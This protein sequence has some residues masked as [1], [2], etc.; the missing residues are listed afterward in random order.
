MICSDEFD[1]KMYEYFNANNKVPQSITEAIRECN[2]KHNNFNGLK[3]IAVVIL[4][5]LTISTS[6]VFA[7][8]I[9][10]FI[11]TQFKYFGTGRGVETAIEHGYIAKSDAEVVGNVLLYENDKIIDDINMN[12]NVEE[13]LITDDNLDIEFSVE[14]DSKINNYVD[15]GKIKNDNI[16]Y[17][18]SHLIILSDL[19]IVD[20]E[21]RVVYSNYY[22]K[23]LFDEFCRNNNIE[24]VYLPYTPFHSNFEYKEI[25]NTNEKVIVDMVYHFSSMEGF[26][27]SKSL[28]IYFSK[29]I[30]EP[31]YS[32]IGRKIILKGDW[33]FNLDIPEIMYN[34]GDDVWYEVIGSENESFE[35]YEARATETSFILGIK[36]N[37]M[38]KPEYPKEL[39]QRQIELGVGKE[40][41]PHFET[42]KDFLEFYGDKKYE[43]L[44]EEY[45]RKC[46]PILVHGWIYVMDWND[47]T[48]GCYLLDSE[49]NRYDYN[50]NPNSR[51]IDGRLEFTN[52]SKY[53]FYC[54]YVMTKYDATE[55]IT[56]VIDF[57]GE[58]VKIEL[59]QI[60]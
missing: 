28:N 36:V 37:D 34:R 59:K 1:K 4:A 43:I 7:K 33:E 54:D 56:A 51:T 55:N 14:F 9:E 30:L 5:I 50:S 49:G 29:I 41:R 48:E 18:E 6:I 60:R 2:L 42:E 44:Y 46:N 52:D 25:Y 32:E 53:D 15:L 47:R 3:N 23:E 45:W 58:P 31:K 11:K 27:K 22:D 13:Y 12:I 35:V 20:D 24:Y 21:N 16:N 38:V 10:K 8:D 40:Y 19:F 57:M 17:E 26:P 39:E